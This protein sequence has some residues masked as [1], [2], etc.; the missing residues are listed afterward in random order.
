M[1]KRIRDKC[2]NRGERGL[3]QLERMFKTFDMNGNGLLEF[4]E[5]ST[6]LKNFKLDLEDFD[7]ENIFKS[8]DKNGD[9]V[10][11]LNE[12]KDFVLGQLSDRR[13][14]IVQEA[15][16]K[17]DTQGRGAVPYQKVRELY[18]AK[19]HPDVCN[20]KRNEEE[21]VNE[22]LEVY[23]MHHNNF[24]N[25][26]KS[27]MVSKDEFFDYYRTLG[28]CYE[29]DVNFEGMVKG[30]WGVKFQMPEASQRA[31]AGGKDVASNAKERYQQANNRGSPFGTS[32]PQKDQWTSHAKSTFTGAPGSETG[33]FSGSP[34]KQAQYV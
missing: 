21:A 32:A 33:S 16:N 20:G 6:A 27:D 18:D 3:F 12:F 19:R 23:E 8:F 1:L 30:V 9:G 2:V 7:I 11:D 31:P 28:A 17:L 10:L 22:F 4:K 14:R 15:W 5:F 26:R 25:M 34:S 29:D 13:A 24:N